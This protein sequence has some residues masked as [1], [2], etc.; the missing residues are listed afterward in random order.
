MDKHDASNH[1][2]NQQYIHGGYCVI[3]MNPGKALI[4]SPFQLSMHWYL[5]KICHVMIAL[6]HTGNQTSL[7]MQYKSGLFF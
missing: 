1:H 2:S 7:P 6:C 5:E 4:Y 3:L